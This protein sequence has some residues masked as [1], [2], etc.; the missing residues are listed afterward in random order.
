MPVKVMCC[1]YNPNTPFLDVTGGCGH[2]YDG[3]WNI[4]KP[5]DLQCPGCG[6]KLDRGTLEMLLPTL[7]AEKVMGIGG[8]DPKFLISRRTREPYFGAEQEDIA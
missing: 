8:S 4:E 3:S 6:R 1:D 5:Q 7:E 2:G